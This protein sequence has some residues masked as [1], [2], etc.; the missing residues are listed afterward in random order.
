MANAR[1]PKIQTLLSGG[2]EQGCINLSELED[3]AT[4]LDMDDQAISELTEEIETRGLEISD[5]CGRQGIELTKVGNGDLA[6]ATTD[7]LQLFMNEVSRYQLL[8]AAEEVELAK[9]IETGDAA[10]KE[11]L[12][13]SN[14]R[15]VVSIARR[16]QGH[17]LALIDLIQEGILGLIR[18]AEKFDWRR[19]YKFSTYATFWIRQ[20]IQRGLENKARTIRM[21]VHIA[22]RQ[23]KVARTEDKLALD[24]DHPPTDAEIAEEAELTVEQVREVRETPRSV[25]SLDRP[26]TEESET[27]LGELLPSDKPGPE[28]EVSLNLRQAAVRDAVEKL[29]E[30]E[31]QIIKLRYGMN[32]DGNPISQSAIARQLGTSAER[33][34]QLETRALERLAL[35][36]EVEGLHEAA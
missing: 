35:A 32:G 6:S 5:D 14:L 33:V 4:E 24:L 26:A 28:E 11:R 18:A 27:V 21:P 13:N 10:A 3:L 30:R 16:Y 31:R 15:L 34:R 19:G 23:R 29:P 7:A 17:D 1:H 8:T 2:D 36:R 20:A 9:R 22:Q 12:I 25:T